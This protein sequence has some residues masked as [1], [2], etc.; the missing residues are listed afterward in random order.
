MRN[1]TNLSHS[2]KSIFR[3]SFLLILLLP[4]PALAQEKS[5]SPA[6]NYFTNTE[7]IN[8]KGER[9]RFYQDVIKNKVVVINTFFTS[10]TTSCPV[11]FRNMGKIQEAFASNVGKELFLISISVDP[12]TDTPPR[13]KAHAEKNHA[14]DGWLFLTGTKE[15][16]DFVLKKIGQY[17]ENKEDHK[18]ILIIG[19]E[20]TG[21]WKKAFGFAKPE[22]LIQ[23]VD[24]VL[25]D[26]K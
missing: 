5:Q 7:L 25:N 17:V 9:M 23:V 1:R 15:N 14:G 22:E 2:L 13:L 8:Q 11:L 21:L 12:V 3:T 10:C 24:S 19:N 26:Q 18:T 6:E 20:R 16:V 4:S